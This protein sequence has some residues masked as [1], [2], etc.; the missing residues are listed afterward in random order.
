M[1]IEQQNPQIRGHRAAKSSDSVG[2]KNMLQLRIT[3]KRQRQRQHTPK[4]PLKR[5]VPVLTPLL[6]GD[7]GVCAVIR[8]PFF[9]QH[10]PDQ[11]KNPQIRGHRFAVIDSRYPQIRGTH[12]A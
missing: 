5:G 12:R 11:Y 4:S 9:V 2:V 6:R 8:K 10:V 7:L 1:V 3:R